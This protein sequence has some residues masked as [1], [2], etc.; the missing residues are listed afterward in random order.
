MDAA[1]SE[2]LNPSNLP[3]SE[4]L[5]RLLTDASGESA[6]LQHEYIGTEHLVLALTR[7][8]DYGAPLPALGV[9]PRRVRT[10]ID[11]TVR[12]GR[13]VL[14]S[15][16]DRPFTSRTKRALSL[17]AE[18]ARALGHTQVG[19]AHVLVGLLREGL[20]I[21]AQVLAHE[22]LTAEQAYEFARRSGAEKR[23]T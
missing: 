21:G 6:R 22:G 16:L 23:P 1:R 13:T 2:G 14:G 8:T 4:E 9:D 7:Q 20:N 19:P 18:S 5:H 10:L 17:A 11:E 3:F 12:P 15:D